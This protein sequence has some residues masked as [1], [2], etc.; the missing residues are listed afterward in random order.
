MRTWLSS[1]LLLMVA[2][3]VFAGSDYAREKNW[4]DEVTPTVVVGDP[5]YLEQ[6]NKHKF[7]GLYAEAPKAKRAPKKTEA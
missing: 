4:A 6:K 1:L 7:L 3:P 2:A 5:I